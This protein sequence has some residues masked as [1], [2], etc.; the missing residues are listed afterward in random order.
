[1]TINHLPIAI[2]GAGP[3]GL[4]VAAHLTAKGEKFIIFESGNTV[5]SSIL[6]WG[7]VRMFSPWQY[8]IDKKAK[9]LLE[10][11]EWVSLNPDD[12]PNG[13]ELVS[14]YLIP[15][16]QLPDI[17]ASLILDAKVVGVVKKGYISL[18]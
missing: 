1:M 17:Q 3:V 13:K 15:L 10:K 18:G 8:N 2:I 5:G 11:T 16:S 9:D 4:A 7:H 12:I 6:E 14:E